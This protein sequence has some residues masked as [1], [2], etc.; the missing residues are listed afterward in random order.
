MGTPAGEES[1]RS[2]AAHRLRRAYRAVGLGI[3]ESM[4]RL[5]GQDGG[6]RPSWWVVDLVSG[7]RGRAREVVAEDL[8]GSIPGH[9]EVTRVEATSFRARAGRVVV[10]GHI[11]C[12]P[13]G[14]R[15]F[16]LCQVPFAHVWTLREDEA[17]RVRSYLDGVELRRG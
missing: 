15:S 6:R 9:W 8:F 1:T 17:V 12:R 13:R 4:L 16:D 7:Q 3:G 5:F 14:V 2:D 10:T 11:C